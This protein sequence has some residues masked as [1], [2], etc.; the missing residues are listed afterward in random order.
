[1]ETQL[2]PW[3]MLE[4][5]ADDNQCTG[6]PAPICFVCVQRIPYSNIC[7]FIIV[8]SAPHVSAKFL[9]ID[10]TNSCP[11]VP[12]GCDA[13]YVSCSVAGGGGSD[14]V[15]DLLRCSLVMVGTWGRFYP[16]ASSHTNTGA[17][18]HCEYQAGGAFPFLI[19]D[20]S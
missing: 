15:E 17:A 12:S 13:Q 1:M 4:Y 9:R 20:I 14:P 16:L 18:R 6:D 11:D 7:L 3:L 10:D 5:C 19:Y 8:Y 2:C